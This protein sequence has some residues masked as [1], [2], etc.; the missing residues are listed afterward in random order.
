MDACD[1]AVLA[2]EA[3][4]GMGTAL[5]RRRACG[6]TDGGDALSR[7]VEAFFAGEGGVEVWF[8]WRWCYRLESVS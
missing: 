1:G 3:G 8:W 7:S 4:Q 2:W 5:R 6:V